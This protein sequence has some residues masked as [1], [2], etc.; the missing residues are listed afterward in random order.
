MRGDRGMDRERR[1]GSDSEMKGWGE[2]EG[3]AK[4]AGERR[5][6]RCETNG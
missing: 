4:K 3:W 5:M 1:G 2:I 6:E